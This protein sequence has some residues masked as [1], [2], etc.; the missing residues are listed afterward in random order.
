MS[1]PEWIN[2][3][4]L[5]DY[6]IRP[7]DEQRPGKADG[8]IL[9]PFPVE[10]ALSGVMKA[11][12]PD[13]RLWYRRTFALPGSQGG[14]RW[15]LHF[16][17]VDWEATVGVNGKIV[18]QH[19]GGYDPFTID[20]TDAL[21]PEPVQE[22]V[23]SV[24][25]PTDQGSQPRGKQ[26]LK[27]GGIMYTANT[28]IWQ[29][30]WLEPVPE[31]RIDA[32]ETVPDVDGG[33]VR[34]TARLVGP[35][36]GATVHV[37]A[38]DGDREVGSAEGPASTALRIKIPGPKL[39]SPDHPFLYDLRVSA[40]GDE[41]KS[42]F[43]MRSI[44]IGKDEAGV[45]R[46]QLNGK[47][48]FQL[49]P[50]DQGW[51]PDGLYT[52]PTDEA[53]KFDIEIIKRFGFNMIRKHVK[54][55]PERWYSWCD[56]L[57][58]LVWQDMP[59]G[60]NRGA[61]A[62]KQFDLELERMIAARFNHPSIVMWVPFN[63]GWGQHDTPR[64][65]EWI[66]RRDPT[67][68][69]NNASGWTDSGT[70]DVSDVHIYP[71]PGMPPLEEKRAAVLGE[72]GGLG[73][74]LPGH[75]WVD[76]NNWGYRTFKDREALGS[77][78]AELMGRLLSLAA[79]GLSAAVYTQTTDCEVEVNGLLTYDREV[80][81]VPVDTAASSHAPFYR[82]MPSLR[83]LS[84]AALT[85]RQSWRYTT[86]APGPDW[87]RP[88]F[89][90]SAWTAG[91]SGFGTKGTPGAI[92]HTE[93]KTGDIWLRR[94]FEIGGPTPSSP[95][96]YIHHDEDAEVYV[97]GALAGRF[98]GY[99]TGY[100]LVPASR[101]AAAAFKPGRNVLAVHCRQT[102]GGQYIDVGVMD[103]VEP[104]GAGNAANRAEP[105]DTF[106]VGAPPA[107]LELSPSYVKHIS[108]GGLPVVSSAKV[109]D[110]ALKEA[111]YLISHMLAHRPE[112][113]EAM[114]KN[115][116][117]CA[118]MAYNERT[119]DIPEHSDLKPKDY[120]NVRARGLGATRVRPAVSGAE[121]NLLCYPG[122]P[123]STENILIHE[124]GHAMHEMGLSTADPTF[125]PRL[126]EAFEH[127]RKA[128]LWKGTYAATNR[129]EYW[130]EGVQSWFD[131]NRENDSQHNHVNTREE[132]KAYDPALAEL[133]KE[134]FGDGSWR[135]VRPDRR[136]DKAHLAG[137][138]PAK[139]P[140]FAW[141]PELLEA[142]RRLRGERARREAEK[143]AAAAPPSAK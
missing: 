63:E 8:K 138:D 29:T 32:L 78:Y 75:L 11:V 66:K 64:H 16:G 131:T 38:F 2:L 43:G 106:V 25:D 110:F 91:E 99:T 125:D 42:Y 115:K 33:E 130:A 104:A 23:V 12:K 113:R 109:S 50:L 132:L 28:G 22:L 53:L 120:W 13:Q 37:W 5:W 123:Y 88:E 17:A 136:Q 1:R 4:G 34:V 6:A 7:K 140:R 62:R 84:P 9:V 137:Y 21:V 77:A 65:V 118:V 129:N 107:A 58:I 102:R 143:R 70:G 51:W 20:I 26:V 35:E 52:A 100:T 128:G 57:G 56:R 117:R 72:F 103:L 86:Q 139:A 79:M 108:I 126:R 30:V 45:T 135:Y 67:R 81:K 133:L 92:V 98:S 41:V 31:T 82:P 60:D 74:P 141:E 44:A 112:V 80:N 71:G 3:N 119:T 76:R 73:L 85:A 54:V 55:E 40:A 93:W 96:L 48:L 18:G 59:S 114:V 97:N 122:D 90:D 24:W 124:F 46:L 27:P 105:I 89:D 83:I 69:V 68:L 19:R 127:A 39:W 49:G 116:V 61:E 111:A 142:N 15:L 95:H 47:P 121:E 134:V 14:K 101:E 94:S 36:A 10:S 87:T